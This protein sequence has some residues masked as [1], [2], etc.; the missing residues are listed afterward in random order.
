M[1]QIERCT[2]R[3]IIPVK[4]RERLEW[5][6]QHLL[7]VRWDQMFKPVSDSYQTTVQFLGCSSEPEVCET[8]IG[9]ALEVQNVRRLTMP[10]LRALRLAACVAILTGL[11]QAASAAEI[12]IVDDKSQPESSLSPRVGH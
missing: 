11:A 3:A 2:S 1:Q 4:P 5:G 10:N 7:P 9:P 6:T 12:L 8:V